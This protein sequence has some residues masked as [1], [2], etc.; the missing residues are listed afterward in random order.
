MSNLV[1]NSPSVTVDPIVSLAKADP[2]ADAGCRANGP[3]GAEV[4]IANFFANADC[5]TRVLIENSQSVRHPEGRGESTAARLPRAWNVLVELVETK[6]L[7]KIESQLSCLLRSLDTIGKAKSDDRAARREY[8]AWLQL[9]SMLPIY[10]RMDDCNL[11]AALDESIF[12]AYKA[13]SLIDLDEALEFELFELL[14]ESPFLDQSPSLALQNALNIDL[15]KIVEEFGKGANQSSNGKLLGVGLRPSNDRC[16]GYWSIVK[17]WT[18]GAAHMHIPTKLSIG[19]ILWPKVREHWSRLSQALLEI[20][21]VTES[22]SMVDSIVEIR[23]SNDP[24]LAKTLDIQLQRCREEQGSM[25][26]VVLKALENPA[27]STKASSSDRL[28]RWQESV[29][30]QLR[31]ATDGRTTRGFICEAGELALI[32]DDLDRNEVT[33][34]IR[35]ALEVAGQPHDCA[36]SMV[37][38]PNIPIVCGVACV[39]SPSKRFQ[40]DQLIQSAWRCLDAAK[41]QGPG[42]VKSIEVF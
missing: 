18:G 28:P 13:V 22:T 41:L 4:R 10:L 35:D 16:D 3:K 33:A 7:G 38:I 29:I 15:Y 17:Q 9:Y 27:S 23:S 42:A 25:A 2:N 32:V 20:Q 36:S 24:Q 6:N 12:I 1:E 14:G 30:E 5:R 34:V 37:E 11:E 19:K 26:L 40:I 21:I 39:S 8:V 31:A